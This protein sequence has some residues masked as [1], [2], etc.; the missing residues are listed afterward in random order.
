MVPVYSTADVEEGRAHSQTCAHC[1]GMGSAEF[2]RN[3]EWNGNVQNTPHDGHSPPYSLEGK[4]PSQVG[5]PLEERHLWCTF[6]VFSSQGVFPLKQELFTEESALIK[7]RK[8]IEK[9]GNCFYFPSLC[10]MDYCL[11]IQNAFLWFKKCTLMTFSVR[12]YVTQFEEMF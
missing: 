4:G 5:L 11:S 12:V 3:L 10:I 6:S 9:G 8:A 2:W 7:R 1:F